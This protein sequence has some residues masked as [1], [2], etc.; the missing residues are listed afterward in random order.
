MKKQL[1]NDF[2]LYRIRLALSGQST[3]AVVVALGSAASGGL[4]GLSAPFPF[5]R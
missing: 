3:P 5:T 1:H 2:R 4:A